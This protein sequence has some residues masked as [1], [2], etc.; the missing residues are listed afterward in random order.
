MEIAWG[1]E[2]N[3]NELY[4]CA[5][6]KSYELESQ[7]AEHPRVVLGTEFIRYLDAHER[8][9][10]DQPQTQYVRTLATCCKEMIS[11][12]EDGV[13]IVDY[14]GPGFKEHVANEID[15]SAYDHAVTFIGEQ[16]ESSQKAGN[17]KLVQRYERLH[18]YFE[19]NRFIWKD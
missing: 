12:D 18:G 8:I 16:L 13:H 15:A 11:L 10:G 14:L 2:L 3:D 6:A 17:D 4:G 5:V 19:R 1:V 7:I 9:P